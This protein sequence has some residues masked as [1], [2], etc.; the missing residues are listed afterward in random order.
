M[1]RD[2]AGQ[3]V[4][5]SGADALA[6]W[7][8]AVEGQLAHA[9]DTP[10]HLARALDLD[11]HFALGHAARGLMLLTLARADMEPAIEAALA[12]ARAALAQRPASPRETVFVA[13][14]SDWAEQSA[15]RRAAQR[16][17]ASLL[18]R[19]NDAVALKFAHAIRFM[20]GDRAAMLASLARA[21]PAYDDR[22][23]LAGYV[24]GCLAF[25]LEEQGEFAAAERA[26]RA[27]VALAP[28]DVRGRHAVAHV[29]EMTGRAAEGVAFLTD[30]ACVAHANNLRFHVFW[31]L[32][33]FHLE[34]GDAAAALR[35]YD[36]DIRAEKTDDFRDIAN[37]ASLL[38]RL[39]F[40]GVKVGERWAEL[41][42]AA[43]GRAQD[44]ALIFAD[45]HYLL[46]LLGDGDE[47]TGAALA[48]RL[49]VDARAAPSSERRRA[50]ASG[51]LAAAGLLAFR[52][53]NYAE[54]AR[55]LGRARA[56]LL[57]IGGSNAQRD[58]F[59]Q[60]WIES[61]IRSGDHA[62]AAQALSRRLA[63]RGS[64]NRWAARR[65]AALDPAPAN[66]LA[67]LAVMAT[68]LALAH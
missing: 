8:A 21:A 27:A 7:N 39:E 66:R 43:R 9:A 5:L 45:L 29:L 4:T 40:S 48:A 20:L 57:S 25:A 58:V 47:T 53:R 42:A 55:L 1:H 51:A 59:E 6:A 65:L 32:A 24:R 23:P 63:T 49:A 18:T 67:A 26:G 41:A 52:R 60:A 13:A 14:L 33:L 12:A 10:R 30:R 62:A 50:A 36:E 3:T 22:H 64:Q 19:P 37:G 56:D 38:A 31:H 34:R 15:P 28:R 61:L 16:L 35:L 11:P 2:I 54:A 17:E 44:G 68:P 46:A